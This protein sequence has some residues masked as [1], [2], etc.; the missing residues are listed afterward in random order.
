[1]ANWASFDTE[2]VHDLLVAY[3]K[4]VTNTPVVKPPVISDDKWEKTIKFILEREG[5]FQNNPHDKGN[6]YNG[7]LIGTKY[8]ISAA[9][10]GGQYDIPNLTL[11]QAKDIYY[12]HY[13]VASGADKLDWP[14]CL[15][16]MDTAVL[17]GTSV[18]I[19][20]LKEVGPNPYLFAAKRLKVYTNLDNWQ[21]FGAGWVNRVAALLEQ[22]G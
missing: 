13:W 22:M 18:A 20:W 9:S 2:P 19:K 12:K 6:Y 8:G 3:D 21:H 14:L 11:D 1:M 16:V 15:L 10:W 17:H 7:Q 5:G 4:S